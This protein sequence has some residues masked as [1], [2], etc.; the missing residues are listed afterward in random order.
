VEWIDAGRDDTIRVVATRRVSLYDATSLRFIS[1]YALSSRLAHGDEVAVV[2]SGTLAT[3]SG[4]S[5]T[6][7]A[8][9]ISLRSRDGNVTRSI[10]VP[11]PVAPD[12]SYMRHIAA[13][14]SGQPSGIWLAE[15]YGVDGYRLTRLDTLG[16][17]TAS[18]H[19]RPAA[20]V[21]SVSFEV[22]FAL[23]VAHSDTIARV[24]T[25]VR[26]LHETRTGL[27]MVVIAEPDSTWHAVKKSDWR[28]HCYSLIEI[29]NPKTGRLVGTTSVRGYPLH[30]LD[31]DGLVTYRED[32]NGLPYVDFWRLTAALPR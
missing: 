7:D 28:S 16:R 32:V 24:A 13:S 9:P 17:S 22:A 4:P 15:H 25:E 14:G 18:L 29:L 10:A 27:V 30:F 12:S 6:F 31:D 5:R 26:A 2:S 20:W 19:R 11:K 21:R 8:A 1:T 3:A 23:I